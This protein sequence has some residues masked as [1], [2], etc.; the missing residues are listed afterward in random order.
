MLI[1]VSK[2]DRSGTMGP[3]LGVSLDISPKLTKIATVDESLIQRFSIICLKDFDT[4][5]KDSAKLVIYLGD[6]RIR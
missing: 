1:C 6:F 4:C 3:Q 2:A 5:A